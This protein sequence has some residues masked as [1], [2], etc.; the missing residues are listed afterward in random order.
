[1]TTQMT[2]PVDSQWTDEQWQAITETGKD[3]L[4]A[5]AAGS[6]K[7]AVLVERIIG[8]ITDPE[9]PMDV[10]RLLIVTFT[11]AAAAEMKARIGKALEKA[12]AERPNSLFLRRQLTLLNRASIMTSHA[13]CMSVV[14]R[15]YYMLDIDPSF[16]VIDETE[17]ALMREEVMEEL[18][19]DYYSSDS[20]GEFYEL[21]DCYSNDRNDLY[22]QHMVQKIY[23]FSRS[24]PWPA[25]W[26]K[27]MTA[28]YQVNDMTSVDDLPWT[29]DLKKIC[30][31]QIKGLMAILNQAGQLINEPGGPTPYADN[32]LSDQVILQNIL[33]ASEGSWDALYKVFSDLSFSR[34]KACKGNEYLDTLKE[35]VKAIR[36]TVKKQ[37]QQMKDEWFSR[38]P[39]SFLEDLNDM[40]GPVSLLAQLVNDFNER[41]LTA[42]HEKGVVDFA[43]LEHYCLEILRHGDS[44]PEG[45]KPSTVAEQYRAQ[46]SEVL[47][48]EY[49]DTNFVQ[50]TILQLVSMD[51]KHGG[52]LFMVG[53]VKQ[54]IYRFRLAEP[55]L[56]LAKYKRFGN[57]AEGC[58][59]DL[60]KNFRSRNE[61]ISGTNY[62][63]KQIMDEEVGE[64][65]YDTDA[66]LRLGA[67]YPKRYVPSELIVINRAG[68][69]GA[70]E[71][72]QD[73]ADDLQVAELEAYQ[74]ADKIKALIG[75]ATGE[76]E[77]VFDRDLGRNRPMAFRDIVI[78]LR[79]ASTT[80]PAM[81]DI[82]K[83]EGIPAYAELSTGY[84]DAIEVS[85]MMSL[86]KV[87]DNPYQDIPLAAVLRSPIVGLNADELAQ[88]RMQDQSSAYYAAAKAY[89]KNKKDGLADKLGHFFQ[90]LYAWRSTARTGSVAELIWQIYRETGYYDYVAGQIGGAQRQANLKALYDRAG[91]YEQ[92]SFRGL[93]RFLRFIER[94]RD[95]GSDLGAARALSEQED[96]VRIMTIHKS[97]GLEYPVVFVA[98]MNKMFNKM[99]LNE[100][101]LLHKTLGLGTKVIDPVKRISLPT[102]PFLA[103]KQKLT[104][105]MLAE[106]MRVLYVALTRAKE[107]LIL[108]GTVRDAK[109][110][111][112]SWQ[113][114]IHE[115]SW[116]LP[117]YDRGRAKTF[118]DWVGPAVIRHLGAEALHDVAEEKPDRHEVSLDSSSWRTAVVPAAALIQSA[119]GQ[120]ANQEDK[121]LKVKEWEAVTGSDRFKEQVE[122]RLN[123]T[124]PYEQATVSMA[125]QTVTEIK[126]Q[127]EF[128]NEG[129]DD[130]MVRVFRQPIG[131]RPRFLQ[132]GQLSAAEKGTAMHMLMQ[133]IDLSQQVTI[134]S[135]KSQGAKL[136]VHE[137][138]APE[139]EQTLDYEA[140]LSFFESEIGRKMLGA[141]RVIRECPFSLVLPAHEAYPQWTGA[142]DE[143]VLV[144]GVIDC[145]IE[146]EGGLTIIDY[147]T[148]H[149]HDK[150]PTP[151]EA[152][153]KL[154][155]RYEKQLKL[156]QTA[157]ERIWKRTVAC[158]GLYAFDG[159]HFI[160]IK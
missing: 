120:T 136:V 118:L 78:L 84:F 58:K 102:I 115:R 122:G 14:K 20:S 119:K 81:L 49:Q 148:D 7:T 144:Q 124:Y 30:R 18:L 39:E 57:G 86:L 121:L 70:D 135:I 28:S 9:N 71:G 112:L 6:G 130:A 151:D 8:K 131:D 12:L 15:Y 126:R 2:K 75:T 147:K 89:V 46:F 69:E 45:E 123:W 101:A 10:D 111:I 152:R 107:K 97:K 4:V 143:Q 27:E 53:D 52:N 38:S 36:E 34:L 47:V 95:R 67:E 63:F 13:F 43:D 31:Q 88:V 87:V 157:I 21:V 79:A 55:G 37:V 11:N 109:K 100:K 134:E 61:V 22:L 26:L 108:I 51:P 116:L 150:Y 92:T 99:D 103:I 56:F 133:H 17:M 149:I 74:I 82:L 105:E 94:M 153:F 72:D 138:L 80:A 48:D 117:A 40:T 125:K 145:L 42:K 93:F 65:D 91:Q 3:I 5:A 77:Q 85:V 19:E 155:E 129:Y 96:V 24:H 140:I 59:I 104:E 76:G 128:F 137:L 154:I 35:Q 16:R 156:Y 160:Q 33:L 127:Q 83:Q 62:I 25:K 68:Q 29:A 139:Q 54:S 106:E 64:I 142:E 141:S 90:Q 132:K 73:A 146:D 1:M 44:S 41:Y 158:T 50:E 32:I 110:T 159:G 113:S 66:E 98:G 60:A 114:F 23:D